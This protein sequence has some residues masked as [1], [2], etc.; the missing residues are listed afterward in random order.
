MASSMYGLLGAV[1]RSLPLAL[2]SPA[3]CFASPQSMGLHA[4]SRN[5]YCARWARYGM[6][7]ANVSLLAAL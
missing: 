4:G 3:L 6:H 7:S 2:A 1:R 5:A